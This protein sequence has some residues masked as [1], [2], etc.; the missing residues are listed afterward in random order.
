MNGDAVKLQ[1]PVANTIY[2]HVPVET[3]MLATTN[4]YGPTTQLAAPAATHIPLIA[5][6]GPQPPHPQA[7]QVAAAPPPSQHQHQHQHTQLIPHTH[8]HAHTHSHSAAVAAAAAVAGIAGPHTQQPASAGAS[9]QTVPTATH[10]TAHLQYAHQPQTVAQVATGGPAVT[11]IDSAEYAAAVMNGTIAQDGSTVCYG[12][13]E[14][15]SGVAAGSNLIAVDVSMTGTPSVAS[16]QTQHSVGISNGPHQQHQTHL[17][18][19]N[20]NLVDNSGI[21][22]DQLKQMLSTQLEYYFS[23]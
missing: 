23:R 1:P 11:T 6:T 5:T 20:T 15:L 4:L 18:L 10:Q 14:D 12:Q 16:H 3:A 21:P 7:L 2:A 22:L 8:P 9:L 19:S 13:Q 17:H